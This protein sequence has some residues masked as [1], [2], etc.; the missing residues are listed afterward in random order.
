MDL[1]AALKTIF[2]RSNQGSGERAQPTVSRSA[3]PD[4]Y[5]QQAAGQAVQVTV[6]APGAQVPEPPILSELLEA[7]SDRDEQQREVVAAALGELGHPRAVFP[8]R[9]AL[10]DV[11]AAVRAAAAEALGKIGSSEGVPGL[12]SALEDREPEVRAAAARS[13]GWIKEP[14][15][16]PRLLEVLRDADED[17]QRAAAEALADIGEPA[18]EGLAAALNDRRAVQAAEALGLLGTPDA[19]PLLLAALKQ[20]EADVRRAAAQALG[21][22]GDPE[23]LSALG[24]ALRDAQEVVQRAA[25]YALAELGP[26]GHSTLRAALEDPDPRVRAAAGCVLS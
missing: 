19:V 1:V 25:A 18:F 21:R 5:W 13:L 14:E 12:M 8:L 11:S 24:L 10:G 6:R 9:Q 7:L 3:I 16:V 17:V 15:G 4:D 20:S 2:R 23:A 22:I 26:E